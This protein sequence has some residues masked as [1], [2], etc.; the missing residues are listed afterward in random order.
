MV[1]T[2]ESPDDYARVLSCLNERNQTWAKTAPVVMSTVAKLRMDRTG[3]PNRHAFHDIGL[4]MGNLSVQATSLGLFV[5]QM[6]GIL[7]DRAREVLGIPE[8]YEAVTGVAIGYK[9]DP[10]QLP[11]ELKKREESPRTRKPATD[12]VFQGEWNHSAGFM[13]GTADAGRA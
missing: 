11:P 2:R 13:S 9:A 3:Q 6:A 5:H 7:P 8:G 10:D 12:F 4:A 1:G